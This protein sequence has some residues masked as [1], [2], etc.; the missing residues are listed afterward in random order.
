MMNRF[1]IIVP[2][3]NSV[4]FLPKTLESIEN[5]LFKHY[6]VCIIDDASTLPEQKRIIERFCLKNGWQAIYH[7]KNL[8]ALQGVVEGIKKLNCQ[9]DDVIVVIDG[10]DWLAKKESLEIIHKAYT[11]QDIYLTWGQCETFP[12]GKMA[13]KYAQPISSMIID[14]QLY[15]DIPFVFWHPGTFKYKLWKQIDD[16]DLRDEDGHY[17]R[18]MKD[19]ATLYPLLEMSGHK[20]LFIEETL[21][22][23]NLTNPLND[24]ATTAPEEIKRVDAYLQAKPRYPLLKEIGV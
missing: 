11:V 10:D 22:I 18:V 21:Y 20:K 1:K 4:D 15:R 19:K 8:G 6:D 16:R 9:D 12:P 23:Y 2:S 7:S 24:Y 3:F 5:Q 13:M 17:F 14:Q